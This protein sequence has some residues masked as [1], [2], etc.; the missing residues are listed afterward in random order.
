[1]HK[2]ELQFD[3]DG[4]IRFIGL[5]DPDQLLTCPYDIRDAYLDVGIL[6]LIFKHL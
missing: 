3:I 1:M 4:M 2:D 6:W 5:E